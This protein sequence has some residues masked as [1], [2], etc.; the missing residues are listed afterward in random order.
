MGDPTGED[1]AAS[2]SFG[3]SPSQGR[4]VWEED[5]SVEDPTWE[6]FS[7]H[8]MGYLSQLHPLGTDSRPS[9]GHIILSAPCVSL[10]PP[11]PL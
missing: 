10:G 4:L 6:D 8:R 7:G 9:E 1:S 5:P 11:D 3:E 2:D